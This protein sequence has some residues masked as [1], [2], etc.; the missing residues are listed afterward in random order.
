MNV[1][2]AVLAKLAELKVRAIPQGIDVTVT[3]DDGA[4][5]DDAVNTLIEHLGIAVA[6]WP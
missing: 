5:A 3:R 4:K 2:D 1:A 6:R